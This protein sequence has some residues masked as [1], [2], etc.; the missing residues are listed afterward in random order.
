MK[1]EKI[2]AKQSEHLDKTLPASESQNQSVSSDVIRWVGEQ[3]EIK[4]DSMPHLKTGGSDVIRWDSSHAGPSHSDTASIN[5]DDMDFSDSS[6]AYGNLEII[7]PKTIDKLEEGT[8]PKDINGRGAKIATQGYM[9]KFVGEEN[10][11]KNHHKVFEGLDDSEE[12]VDHPEDQ[13]KLERMNNEIKG[14]HDR[15][16][17]SMDRGK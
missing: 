13:A 7:N 17:V 12:G 1:N 8:P 4:I 16:G 14:W 6:S 3:R 9:R 2:E 11:R 5:S 15:S 10:T